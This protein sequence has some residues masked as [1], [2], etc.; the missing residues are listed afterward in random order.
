LPNVRVEV[1]TVFPSARTVQIS[2]I[3]Q[4]DYDGPL[5]LAVVT[6]TT[7]I[8]GGDGFA[9][10]TLVAKVRGALRSGAGEAVVAEFDR[11]LATTRYRIGDTRYERPMFR[12]EGVRYFA[13]GG[14]FPR[15]RRR[16][17]IPGVDRVGYEIAIGALGGFASA[18]AG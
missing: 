6:M 12:L 18:L 7:L 13:V 2:S 4:L 15:I 1:K 3:D 16:D 14:E 8:A 10:A 9:P 17:L 11:R 5:T